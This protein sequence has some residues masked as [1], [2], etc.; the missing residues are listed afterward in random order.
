MP[1]ELIPVLRT[2]CESGQFQRGSEAASGE[3]RLALFGGT[4]RPVDVL[5]PSSHLFEPLRVAMDNG[6]RQALIPIEN[7][8]SFFD[9]AA[10]VL[11]HV[12]PAFYGDPKTAAMKVPG[13]GWAATATGF[14]FSKPSATI[15][16]PSLARLL[17]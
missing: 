15:S 10:D 8:R 1:K 7:R 3:A 14:P 2:F 9:V 11:E 12:D 17:P 5:V 6:A 16:S 13:G 4:N